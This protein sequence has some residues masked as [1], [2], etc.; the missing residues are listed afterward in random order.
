MVNKLQVLEISL[1]GSCITCLGSQISLKAKCN[2]KFMKSCMIISETFA[3]IVADK[4][5]YTELL[6]FL[7]QKIH[8]G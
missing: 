8:K 7:R 1:L 3:L 6:V 2:T 5:K 4:S